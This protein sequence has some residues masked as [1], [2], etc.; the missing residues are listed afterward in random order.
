MDRRALAKKIGLRLAIIVMMLAACEFAFR[1]GVWDKLAKPGSY[2]GTVVMIKNAVKS[3]GP[4]KVDFLTIGD[5]IVGSGLN[6]QEIAGTAKKY[7]FTHV[8]VGTGGMHWMSTDFMI[9]WVKEQSPRLQNAVIATN[10]NNFRFAGN[11]E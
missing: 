8:H 11:G 2:A 6:H 7:G 5:S 4:D 1:Y 3:L 9:R 10:V